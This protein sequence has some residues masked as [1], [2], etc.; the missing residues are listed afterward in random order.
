[1]TLHNIS[2]TELPNSLTTNIDIASPLEIVKILRRTDTQIFNG[3]DTYD[4][5]RDSSF[6]KSM[7][8]A[9]DE[10]AKILSFKGKRKIIVAGAGTSGRLSMF[11]CRAF[12]RMALHVGIA[13]CF[14]YLIAGGDL[15]LIKAKEGAEDDPITAQK[16]LEEISG[17]AEK[18]L[19]IGVTCGFSAPYIAGQL[20]Y[21]SDREKFF[22]IL[23][24]FNPP[25]LAR[26]IKIENWDKCFFDVV[27]NIKNHPRC[28]ILN[29]IIGPEPITG[30][31][32]MK[33]G[34][35]TKILLEVIFT[36]AMI[37]ANLLSPNQLS[38]NIK[39]YSL[40]PDKLIF[41]MIRQYENAMEDTY[42][43]GNNVSN[44]INMGG[45]ALNS[46]KHIY[47]IGKDVYGILG[48][49]D[50]SECP[51][52]F[53]DSFEDVRGYLPG[54]WQ[55][56][57]D[58]KEDLSKYGKEYHI[59]LDDFIRDNLPQLTP[60]DL[61]IIIGKEQFILEHDDLLKK[62]KDKESKLGAVIINPS[63]NDLPGFD[64][65]VRLNINPPGLV[66]NNEMLAEYSTK[67]VLNAITTGAH[68]LSGKVYQNR[69]IDLNISNTKLYYRTIGIIQ[70]ILK[71]DMDTAEESLLKSIYNTDKLTDDQ[72]KAHISEHI[73]AGTR[74]KKIVPKALLIAT[75]NFTYDESCKAIEKEPIVRV[76]IEKIAKE[77]YNKS[78]KSLESFF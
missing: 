35:A 40:D 27:A 10:T 54:G 22:S 20:D 39:P 3:W 43:Q 28:V 44:L 16:E 12:N 73:Y 50:A 66:R 26:K 53:G 52:T 68:I 75:G 51:P 2:I 74:S 31:T 19:Y 78:T 65:L 59:C 6:L 8:R 25:E 62:I 76:V 4:G 9:I 36:A 24:G 7:R 18:I 55:E 63:S 5:L 30:S 41:N 77:T 11:I 45:G 33:G 32:R 49:V 61:I 13:P 64:A 60:E 38:K 47:Y 23:L 48:T 34:S 69:M 42:T 46:Q 58:K 56:L 14:H 29:P 67:L 21:A 70:E 17:D 57:L 1:M 72:I 15:A 37:K 71:V